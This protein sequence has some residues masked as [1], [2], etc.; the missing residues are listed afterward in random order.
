ML[1]SS[2]PTELHRHIIIFADRTTLCTLCLVDFEIRGYALRYLYAK[3]V[4]RLYA[5]LAVCFPDQ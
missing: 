1:L 5:K 4:F 3:L 2:L